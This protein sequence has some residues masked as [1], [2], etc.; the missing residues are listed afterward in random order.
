MPVSFLFWVY[1]QVHKPSKFRVSHHNCAQIFTYCSPAGL[2]DLGLFTAFDYLLHY[3]LQFYN[4]NNLVK[5]FVTHLPQRCQ[6]EQSRFLLSAVP[7]SLN[8]AQDSSNFG[9]LGKEKAGKKAFLLTFSLC[10]KQH[11]QFLLHA[12]YFNS[13]PVPHY[14][15]LASTESRLSLTIIS[16]NAGAGEW[17]ERPEP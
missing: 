13:C 14:L 7:L 8:T 5:V 17:K 4:V 2:Q 9:R 16:S 6:T 1:V 12:E 15:P 3:L 11:Q 10:L